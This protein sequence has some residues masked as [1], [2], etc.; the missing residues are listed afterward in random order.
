[1]VWPI[2]QRFRNIELVMYRG[3]EAVKHTQTNRIIGLLS[4]EVRIKN[5]FGRP[6][7]EKR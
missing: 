7:S 2:V 4:I 5:A 1:M 6:E 3:I